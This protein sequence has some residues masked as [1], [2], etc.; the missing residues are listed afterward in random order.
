MKPNKTFVACLFF[1]LFM[2]INASANDDLADFD[3]GT[4][5]KPLTKELSQ[6]EAS[7]ENS[8]DLEN[9]D[10]GQQLPELSCADEKLKKQ[11]ENFVY[12]YVNIEATNSVVEQRERYLLARNLHDFV[13]EDEKHLSSKETYAAASVVAYLK[14]NKNREIHKVCRSFGNDSKK[15]EDL[16]AVIYRDGAYYQVVVPNVINSTKELDKATFTYNW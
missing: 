10:F 3:A 1:A 11:V 8:S 2:M 6:E 14:I 7:Q 16:F 15:F 13:Q 5:I 9:V 4:E 12:N